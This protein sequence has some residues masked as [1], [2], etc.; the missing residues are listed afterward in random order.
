MNNRF[1]NPYF[2]FGLIAVILT[3]MGVDAQ[4]LTSWG[5]LKEAI[6]NL[7]SNPFL[8]GSVIVAITGVVIDPTT[9][10][11]RDGKM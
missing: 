8:L 2:Y 9:K 4:T 11:L 5:A 7:L 10:G 3:A 1:K 6:I